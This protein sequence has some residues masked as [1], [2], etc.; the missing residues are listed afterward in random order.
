M[1]Y[2]EKRAAPTLFDD[3]KKE[4]EIALQKWI[5]NNDKTGDDL[6]MQLGQ[7]F[8]VERITHFNAKEIRHQLEKTLYQ[9]QVGLCCYCGN[10]IKRQWDTKSNCWIYL[11]RA[12]EHFNPKNKFKNATFDYQNLLF[13]CKESQSLR[14]YEIGKKYN[15]ILVKGFETVAELTSLSIT[16]IK[17][18]EKNAIIAESI[19]KTGD[20]IF[21]P[22]PAHCDDEKSKYDAKINQERIINPTNIEEKK[23]IEALLFSENGSI[24]Y[25]EQNLNDEDKKIIDNTFKVLGLN[26]TTLVDRRK[27]KW[28]FAT[29]VLNDILEEW[30]EE[31]EQQE[32]Y[33]ERKQKEIMSKKIQKLIQE[34]AKPNVEG[35]I[36]PFY[37]V[38]IAYLRT[39]FPKEG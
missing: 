33:D 13:S 20:K 36:E 17:S 12:I 10:E 21:V 19:L 4:N 14:C 3:W 23:R 32:I 25:N 26:C 7:T 27:E 16:L 11:H 8:G 31:F 39:L 29:R 34:K 35:V 6:W 37:F 28:Y 9:E 24:T 18:Y 22:N 1:R 30:Y 5:E 38:E 15:G 2:I